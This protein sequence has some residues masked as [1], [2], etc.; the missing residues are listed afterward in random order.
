MNLS[1]AFRT[2]DHEALN[3]IYDNLPFVRTLSQDNGRLGSLK[4]RQAA[5]AEALLLARDSFI[6]H[7]SRDDSNRSTRQNPHKK[8]QHSTD[9]SSYSSSSEEP[10]QTIEYPPRTSSTKYQDVIGKIHKPTRNLETVDELAIFEVPPTVN[11]YDPVKDYLP[12]WLKRTYMYWRWTLK[13]PSHDI[14]QRYSVWISL[15]LQ[16]PSI[17]YHIQN[18]TVLAT[19]SPGENNRFKTSVEVNEYILRKAAGHI[20][21]QED[22]ARME[23][24]KL[25]QPSHASVISFNSTFLRIFTKI[26]HFYHPDRLAVQYY[27]KISP[28]I[29]SRLNINFYERYSI[30]TNSGIL[31]HTKSLKYPT[32]ESLMLAAE[33]IDDIHRPL[34]PVPKKKNFIELLKKH[35]NVEKL[36]KE[37]N[38]YGEEK[39]MQNSQEK[40]IKSKKR[41]P[42]VKTS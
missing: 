11:P 12:T 32:L 2:L 20:R 23:F 3:T 1:H 27:D 9:S 5:L 10:I 22:S 26:R 39:G 6:S 30:T 18:L 7:P 35:E 16:H 37:V 42:K 38:I 31:P 15:H 28:R 40:N 13:L 36:T 14:P 41:P 34:P 24:S 33:Q 25:L 8:V 21:I 4:E 17:R 19:Q 29:R